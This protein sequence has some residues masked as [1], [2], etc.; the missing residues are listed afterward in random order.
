MEEQAREGALETARQGEGTHQDAVATE[1]TPDQADGELD[2]ENQNK[3]A[4]LAQFNSAHKRQNATSSSMTR[5][6]ARVRRRL[7]FL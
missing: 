5:C 6:L 2:D 4:Y 1:S 7:M 3:S